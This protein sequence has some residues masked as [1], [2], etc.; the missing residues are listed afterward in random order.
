MHSHSLS[1]DGEM[2]EIGHTPCLWVEDMVGTVQYRLAGVEA[3]DPACTL[4]I[5]HHLHEPWVSSLSLELVGT[6]LLY[7]PFCIT[8]QHRLC[9]IEQKDQPNTAVALDF[10]R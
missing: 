3:R 8:I 5:Q 4:H 6:F 2:V 7:E 1:S 9:N 10:R